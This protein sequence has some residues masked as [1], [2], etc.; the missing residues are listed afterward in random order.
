MK[1]GVDSTPDIFIKYVSNSSLSPSGLVRRNKP[2]GNLQKISCLTSLLLTCGLIHEFTLSYSFMSGMCD[3]ALHFVVVHL[4]CML[5]CIISCDVIHMVLCS[6]SVIVYMC[7][8]KVDYKCSWT[9]LKGKPTFWLIHNNICPGTHSSLQEN[10]DK[11][12]CANENL[13]ADLERWHF[14]KKNDLKKLFI[15]LA[16]QQIRY[17]EQVW[18]NYTKPPF[19]L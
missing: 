11:V 4:I 15:T 9:D 3:N 19:Y 1:S 7:A 12:E 13:R 18:L 2:P 10:Q 5:C 8:H 14:E 6:V 17:Y 16:N